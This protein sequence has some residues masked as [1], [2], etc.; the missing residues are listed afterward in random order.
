MARSFEER[1][2]GSPWVLVDFND[3]RLDSESDVL[4]N[5]SGSVAFEGDW[6]WGGAY[7]VWKK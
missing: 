4:R 6:G 5:R 7:E 1:V 3:L 2:T